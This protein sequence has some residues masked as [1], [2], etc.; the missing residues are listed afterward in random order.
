MKLLL[1][2]HTLLSSIAESRRLSAPTRELLART[3][4]ELVFSVASLWEVALKT[5]QGRPGFRVDISVMRRNLVE[6]GYA[7]LPVVGAHVAGLAGLPAIHKDPF[8][9]MLVAQALVEGITLLTSD[10]TVSRYPGP[11]QRV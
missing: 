6:D 5:A 1:D 9:C 7:E 8:D 4:N 11:I 2:T 10:A 3:E